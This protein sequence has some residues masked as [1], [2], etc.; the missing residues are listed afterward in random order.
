MYDIFYYVLHQYLGNYFLLLTIAGLLGIFLLL[1][2][3]ISIIA[4]GRLWL[5]HPIGC[6][7]FIL[8]API[9]MLMKYITIILSP[10]LATISVLFGWKNLPMPL[11]LLQTHDQ[12]LDAEFQG[13]GWPQNT[14]GLSKVYH[15]MRWLIRN[16]AYGIMHYTL[17]FNSKNKGE[18]ITVQNADVVNGDTLQIQTQGWGISCRGNFMGLYI[19]FGWKLIRQ[20]TDGKRMLALGL[21]L[22]K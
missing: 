14:K 6:L 13:G 22:R 15:R 17:G 21:K 1:P 12:S 7:L 5:S 11:Y 3:L 2:S 16:P 8:F 19:W 20:D 9:A 10:L 18:L 4:F